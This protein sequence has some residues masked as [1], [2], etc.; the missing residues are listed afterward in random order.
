LTPGRKACERCCGSGVVSVRDLSDP[1]CLLGE[2]W[3]MIESPCHGCG[4][5]G[6]VPAG[7][8]GADALPAAENEW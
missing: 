1:V 4:G 6:Q 7:K 8:S 2:E 5:T 3:P